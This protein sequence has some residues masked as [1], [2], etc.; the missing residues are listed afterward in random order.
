MSAGARS[1]TVRAKTIICRTAF[2]ETLGVKGKWIEGLSYDLYGQVGINSMHDSE[3]GFVNTTSAL[4]A[5]NV[6][7]GLGGVPTCQSVVNGTDPN[8]VPWNI[9]AKGG[10]TPAAINYI[11]VP[12]TYTI[13]TKEFIVDGSITA[14]L[15]KMGMKLPTASSGPSINLG[16]EYR[17]ESYIFDPDFIFKNGLNSGGNG[18]QNPIDGGFHV[19][20]VFTE[21]RLPLLND[22]PAAYDLSLEAGYRYSS[23]TSGFNTN[24]YKF[25]VEYAPL[26]DVRLRAGYNRA[27]R[28]PGVGDLFAPSV[29]GAGGTADPC[30]GPVIGGTGGTTGTIQGHDFAYCA[31][32]GV[33]A[34]EWGNIATNPAAQINTSV[35]GNIDLKPEIADTF[36]Y[37]LVFQ[38]SFVPGLLATLDF[39]YIRIQDTIISLTSNTIVNNCGQNG[40]GCDLIHRG[41]GTGSLWFNNNDFVT[42]TEQ[43]IGT[44]STK[45]IDSDVALLVRHRLRQSGHPAERH[46]RAELLH[47]PDRRRRGV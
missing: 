29:I 31:R 25:G 6:V 17:S 4:N 13:T 12:A 44:I 3:G 9:F 33:T 7:A 27:V 1:K 38:P 42:A 8:C 19:S 5:L 46:S 41:A 26:H 21:A 45:G 11:S 36:T 18:A 24:T 15:E 22:L 10:V 40:I 47:G 16:A 20:E 2:R 28:A 23:Y 43:N 32:T 37:G 14:D 34:A 39:Y 30:W 35:G